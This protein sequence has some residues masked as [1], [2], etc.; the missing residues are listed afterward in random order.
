MREGR[1]RKLS[2]RVAREEALGQTRAERASTK[3]DEALPCA[4]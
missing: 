3:L 4:R 2:R 1:K